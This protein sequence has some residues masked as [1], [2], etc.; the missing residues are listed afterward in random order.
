MAD[1]T[2]ATVG[3][4]SWV[5]QGL[6]ATNEAA[7]AVAVKDGHLAL[8]ITLRLNGTKISDLPVQLFGPGDVIGIDARE[9]VRTDPQHLTA[10]FEPNYFP[11]VEFN[12]PHFPWMVTPAVADANGRLQPWL[13]LVVVPRDTATLKG[14]SAGPLPVLEIPRQQLPDLADAWAWAHAQIVTGGAVTTVDAALTDTDRNISR[15]VSPRRLDEGTAYYACVVPT[16][17]VGRKAGLGEPFTVDDEKALRPAWGAVSGTVAQTSIT[18]PV[19]YHWEFSTGRAGDF[20]AL[21]R[22]LAP[23]A[24]PDEVGVQQVDVS[25]P[26]WGVGPFPRNAAGAV[27]QLE[28]ALRAPGGKAQAWSADV[29]VPFRTALRQALAAAGTPASPTGPPPL[30]GPPLYGQWYARVD[31]LPADGAPPF[32]F[33]E[34]NLDPQYR[35][36]AG[37]GATVVRFEQEQWAADAWD[38]LAAHGGNNEQRKRDQLAEEVNQQ[39]AGKHLSALTPQR[40]IQITAPMRMTIGAPSRPIAAAPESSVMFRRINRA[41]GPVARRS[42]ARGISGAAPSLAGAMLVP[43]AAGTLTA[44]LPAAEEQTELLRFAPSFEAPMYEALRDFF[45]DM[46][47]P[48][49]DRLPA[50][51]I[52]LLETNQ[53]FVEAFMVGANHEIGRELLWRGYPVDRRGTFFRQFW[54]TRGRVSPPEQTGDIT[55]MGGWASTT[56]LGEHALAGTPA[57]MIVLALRGDLLNRYPRAMVYAV[58]AAWS[59]P[60]AGAARTLGT[61][62]LYPMFRVTRAPEI[63]MVGFAMTAQQARGAD[64]PTASGA[65]P[66]PSRD[67]GWFFVLQE[68]PTEPRFGLDAPTDGAYGTKPARWADLSWAHLAPGAAALRLLNYVPVKGPLQ[69]LTIG[70][71]AWGKNG[72]HFAFITRQNR[73]RLAVHARTWLDQR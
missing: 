8:P 52:T 59:S 24:L 25:A 32:W 63:T 47:L 36:A 66:V 30:V 15:L 21:A 2:V 70:D 19:Y 13:C 6:A 14:G 16:F 48:G 51:S 40:F 11:C 44:V 57:S 17:E 65:P 31:T 67:A 4:L 50:N 60:A 41:A 69:N 35:I 12:H 56:H 18:L 73:F 37:L 7:S 54:D 22:R 23:R 9:V 20:E 68:Q 42:A 72:A 45:P 64:Q 46:L 39:L 38:Q 33:S 10:G 49:L 58:E 34:L 43:R 55:A 3:F 26:G 71:A 5:R 29:R 1:P 28:G 62:E 53:K 61:R 27:M